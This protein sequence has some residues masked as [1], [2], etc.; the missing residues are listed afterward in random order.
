MRF[1]K[2]NASRMNDLPKA[3]ILGTA[4][5]ALQVV[6][7]FAFCMPVRAYFEFESQKTSIQQLLRRSDDMPGTTS[8]LLV[9][10]D[11]DEF[12]CNFFASKNIPPDELQHLV[13]ADYI[14]LTEVVTRFKD[15][16]VATDFSVEDMLYA[17]L[18]LVRLLK[19]YEGLRKSAGSALKGLEVPFLQNL[20][21]QH[22]VYFFLILSQQF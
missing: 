2:R 15:R 18:R 17:N 3:R 1:S 6:L 20:M 5:L 22:R 11:N 16:V 4:I 13:F 12:H 14:P 21:F 19:E 7:I 8:H 9:L 10:S